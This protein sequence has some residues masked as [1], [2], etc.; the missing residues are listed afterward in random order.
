VG[1]VHGLA[2]G[3]GAV[4]VDEDDLCGEAAQEEG[5]SRGGADVTRS[6]DGDLDGLGRGVRLAGKW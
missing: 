2:L 3:L 6:D 5:V 4:D 1:H